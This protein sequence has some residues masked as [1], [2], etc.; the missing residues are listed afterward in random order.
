MK[1][2]TFLIVQPSVAFIATAIMLA[3]LAFKG[4][5]IKP[6]ISALVDEVVPAL[7]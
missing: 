7:A 3:D 6:I 2:P 5:D 4:V 1:I